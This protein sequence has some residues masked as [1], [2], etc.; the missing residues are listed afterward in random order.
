[1]QS[2]KQIGALMV[3]EFVHLCDACVEGCQD[4]CMPPVFG[5]LRSTCVSPSPSF[6]LWDG[7]ND[8]RAHHLVR[9]ASPYINN[10][11]QAAFLQSLFAEHLGLEP[12]AGNH[13]SSWMMVLVGQAGTSELRLER[14]WGELRPSRFTF[15][16][17]IFASRQPV[18]SE[19]LGV[20]MS[21]HRDMEGGLR[22]F[23]LDIN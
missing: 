22:I 18:F 21:G 1:M 6:N 12:S 8:S 19:W 9:V 5:S 10:H 2:P 14:S 20:D 11:S 3:L 15:R 13:D 4:S 16:G 17:T 23:L 7:F